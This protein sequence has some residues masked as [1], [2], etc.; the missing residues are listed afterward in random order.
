M[1]MENKLKALQETK[2]IFENLKT[3]TKSILFSEEK[4]DMR[5]LEKLKKSSYSKGKLLLELINLIENYIDQINKT[6]EEQ[7]PTRLHY[8]EKRQ[9]DRSPLYNFDR[10]FQLMHADVTSLEFLRKSATTR[11]YTLLIVDLYSSK[12]YVYLMHS[13]KRILQRLQQF[14]KEYKTKEKIETCGCKWTMNSNR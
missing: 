12:V 1:K 14:Y 9:I 8:V 3:D 11:I 5:L 10:P 2:N 6:K 4:L 13:R 7:I